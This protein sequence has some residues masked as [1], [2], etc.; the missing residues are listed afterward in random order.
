[1]AVGEK[2]RY[3]ARNERLLVGERVIE[4]DGAGAL[5]APLEVAAPAA[6]TSLAHALRAIADDG[7]SDDVTLWLSADP[8][9]H[10]DDELSMSTPVSVHWSRDEL[11]LV[12]YSA[13]SANP[14]RR[15]LQ[16]L[17]ARLA[18]RRGAVL[19]RFEIQEQ[20]GDHLARVEFAPSLRARTLGEVHAL[21]EELAALVEAAD[22][23]GTLGP[24]EAVELIEGGHAAALVGLPESDWLEAKRVP[25]PLADVRG[26]LEMA[27]D[28]AAFA[29][30]GGGI[31]V[32]GIKTRR[33]PEGEV[34]QEV[35]RCRFA[36]VSGRRYRS[37]IT[38]RVV[39]V[40]EGLRVGRGPKGASGEGVAYV[41]VPR[42]AEE[43]KPFLVGGTILDGRVAGAFVSVPVRVGEDTTAISPAAIQAQLRSA[44]QAAE[45]DRELNRIRGELERV[46][47]ASSPF[48]DIVEAAR[49][50]GVQVNVTARDASFTAPDGRVITIG[51]D[52]Q[53]VVDPLRREQLLEKLQEFGVPMIRTSRGFLRP[54]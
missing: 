3:D 29:N 37:V 45:R 23:T 12:A 20:R 15:A 38:R 2:V 46:A 19:R 1:V 22:G 8:A 36:E 7:P 9:E 34:L 31:V 50:E 6:L 17:A 54:V 5:G 44:T 10:F 18:E 25:Y 21:G 28:I 33:T 40:V 13:V 53:G 35:N 30:A 41:L 27:K 49:R 47:L 16:K 51:L 4:W 48:N 43:L 52:R 32:I 24:S 14:D 42:Q 39:P 26:E 11:R